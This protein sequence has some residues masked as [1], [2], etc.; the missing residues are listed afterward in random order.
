MRCIF[1][2]FVGACLCLCLFH[3]LWPRCMGPV[4]LGGRC[5]CTVFNP[6][7]VTIPRIGGC[8][9]TSLLPKECSLLVALLVACCWLLLIPAMITRGL[10]LS[11]HFPF[12]AQLLPSEC[13]CMFA[14]A[15]NITPP[16][17]IPPQLGLVVTFRLVV[18][19]YISSRV[20]LEMGC[21][22]L[23]GRPCTHIQPK[24]S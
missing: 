9:A 24:D 5:R 8:W 19:K 20:S 6:R 14:S 22:L 11:R 16:P 4:L 7:V 23:L 2:C 12:L 1:S 13:A 3:C 18:S 15:S 10:D 17:P 21:G